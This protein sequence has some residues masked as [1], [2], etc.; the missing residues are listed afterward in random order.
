MGYEVKNSSNGLEVREKG[1][2]YV[3]DLRNKLLQFSVSV[4]RFLLNLPNKR[5]YDVFRYQL[6]KSAT[7]IG[8]N[9]EEE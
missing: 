4:I 7:S 1:K 5:E 8:A 3:V 9:Y 6:S 2:E